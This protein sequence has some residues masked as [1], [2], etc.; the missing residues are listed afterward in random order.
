MNIYLDRADLKAAGTHTNIDRDTTSNSARTSTGNVLRDGFALDISGTVMDN[1]AYAGHGRTAEEVML[2]AGQQD[3]ATR[4]DYM[5]VM[6][7]C[8]SDEDFAKLNKE[9]FHPGSTEIETVVT[10]V[11]HIK[12][13]M[14]KGGTQVIGYTDTVDKETLK[15]ITG[16]EVFAKELQSEFAKRDI[17]VTEENVAAVT[18]AWNHLNE[19]GDLTEGSVKYMIEN[20]LVPSADNLYTAKFSA[21]QDGSRQGKGYYA[22]GSVAGY[23]A[24]KPEQIDF[25]QLLPQMKKVIE[26]AGFPSTEENMEGAKWLVEKGIPLN[27]DTYLAYQGIHKLQFPVTARQFLQTAA[28]AIADGRNPARTDLNLKETAAERAETL[29]GKTQQLTEEAVDVISAKNLPFNLKNLFAA[30]EAL[31]QNF[32]GQDTPGGG[33]Q[34]EE[35][36]EEMNLQQADARMIKGRLLLEEVRLSMTVEA[37]MKLLKSGYQIET[38]PI[39]DLIGQLKEAESTYEKV[40]TGKTDGGKAAESASLYKESLNVLQGI[41]TAPAAIIAQIEGQDTLTKVFGLGQNRAL[42]YQR[43]GETY[44]ALMTAPR[45]DMGDSIQKAFRNVDDILADMDLALTDENRRA[46]RILGYNHMEINHENIRKIR[47]KDKQLTDVISEMKPARVLQMIR[48]GMNPIHMPL[49]DLQNYL[50]KQENPA[51][52]ME[53][54][55][56]FLYQLENQKGISEE[57]RSAYIGIYRLLR[58]VEKGDDAAVGALLRTGAEFT[59]ENLLSAVRTGKRGHMDYRVD[60]SFG[61]AGRKNSAAESITAQIAK[62][63]QNGQPDI[64]ELKVELKQILE[65]ITGDDKAAAEFDREIFEE[66]RRSVKTEEDVIR[67]LSDYSRPITADNIASLRSMLKDPAGIWKKTKT[68]NEELKETFAE[69]SAEAMPLEQA[70]EDVVRAL[71]DKESAGKAYS[72]F[73]EMVQDMI[74]QAV[75]LQEDSLDVRAMGSLFKQMSFMGSMAGEENYEIPVSIDGTLTSI[76]LKLIH[77]DKEESK[78]TVTFE[79]DIFGKTAAEF[80]LT[81]KGISG[82]C[83]CSSKETTEVLKNNVDLLESR[84]VKEEIA[85]GEIYFVTGSEL[86][87]EEISLRESQGRKQIDG[88]K[89]LYRAARAFIGFVQEMGIK[90]GSEGYEN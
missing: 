39:E 45:R 52:D 13:A 70:G 24:K 66:V 7:N 5:A 1:S 3:I 76:N 37:N 84:F 83:V 26:E 64:Q 48:E 73:I 86:N 22:A 75:Y 79:T 11:D 2:E 32:N 30:Q 29:M 49:D 6:S 21:T 89:E 10:I 46:V 90:K 4:R 44:E 88:S 9:G 50:N 8:M 54:Y 38:A 57:E 85:A 25:E 20:N 34:T 60:D 43:A 67:Q 40:L 17:P 87:L 81:E 36:L 28:C 47:E 78:A 31:T 33:P 69:T 55:S 65:E 74:E 15:N 59:L 62:G 51:D 82:F 14:M 53:S 56:K 77:N 63:F 58:Q 68:L 19:A 61:G 35:A 18:E 12:A 42:E 80:K 16:S 23:Y 71:S 27:T 72:N 41:K